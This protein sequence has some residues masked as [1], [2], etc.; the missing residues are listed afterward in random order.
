M[1]EVYV[2][3]G[4]KKEQKMADKKKETKPLIYHSDMRGKKLIGGKKDVPEWLKAV[5][6]KMGRTLTGTLRSGTK[7]NVKKNII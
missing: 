5:D 4:S 6:S 2:Q 7:K 3:H 1:V